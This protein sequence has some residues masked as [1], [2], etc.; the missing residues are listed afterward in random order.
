[1]PQSLRPPADIHRK[2]WHLLGKYR[3]S[4]AAIVA[5]ALLGSVAWAVPRGTSASADPSC[6]AWDQSASEAVARLVGD[7]G[8]EGALADAVFRL[9]RAR[10]HCRNGFMTLAR[11]DYD[12]LMNGR[13]ARRQ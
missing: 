1:M 7:L 6:T 2:L 4:A 12:A 10:S 9:K 5:I 8:A 3:I 13:Y 11:Q